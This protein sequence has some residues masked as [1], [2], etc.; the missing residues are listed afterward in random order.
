[1]KNKVGEL[2]FPDLKKNYS[3]TIVI[4]TGRYQHEDNIEQWS[5]IDN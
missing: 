2:I 4:R 1:M 5:G 3:N